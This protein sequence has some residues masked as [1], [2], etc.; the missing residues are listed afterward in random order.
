MPNGPFTSNSSSI[1]SGP[2]A[3][4][5][6]GGG[7]DIV[8]NYV[9]DNHVV[10]VAGA[11]VTFTNMPLA[12]TEVFSTINRRIYADLTNYTSVRIYAGGGTNG[13]TAAELRGQYSLDDGANWLYLDGAAGPTVSIAA[14]NG[15]PTQVGSF[16]LLEAGAKADVLLRIAGIGGN[17]VIDPT[18]GNLGL[19][20]I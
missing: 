6:G 14:L 9:G 17:G 8:T 1:N 2:F 3:S 13:D 15:N 12:L 5:P 19:E 11:A 7:G 16:V 20:F 4:S 18:V 10:F